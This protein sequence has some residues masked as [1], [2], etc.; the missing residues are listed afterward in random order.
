MNNFTERQQN[1]I[2]FITEH[3]HCT[4]SQLERELGCSRRTIINEIKAI[5]Q[6]KPLIL[7]TNKGYSINQEEASQSMTSQFK[8]VNEEHLLLRRL[9][10]FNKTYTFHELA[11]KQF[12]SESTL[13][14]LLKA[15]TPLL[16]S[17]DLA[18]KREKGYVKVIG[19]EFS[20]RK[21]I[22]Y[23]INEEIDPTFTSLENIT[24][25]FNINVSRI[26]NI[27]DNAIYNHHYYLDNTYSF[28]LYLNIIIALYRMKSD[29]YIDQIPYNTIDKSSVEYQISKE[30]CYQYANH[31]SIS[32][33]EEDIFYIALLLIGQIKPLNVNTDIRL[34][35]PEIISRDLINKMDKVLFDTFNYYMMNINYK[36]FLYNFSLHI[37]AMIKRIKNNQTIQNDFL[38]NIK[39][40]CPF[41]YEVAV[42]IAQK[43]QTEY[44]IIIP[45]E[46]IGFISVHIGFLINKSVD[47]YNKIKILLLCTDYHH[48]IENV[49]QKILANHSEYVEITSY[50]ITSIDNKNIDLNA[51]IIIS[52]KHLNI[53]GKKII[54][55][56]PFYT[57]M[58]HITV[59]S[60]I[61]EALLEK[62]KTYKNRLLSSFFH[63]NLF[64]KSDDFKTKEEVI[65]FLGDK[66]IEF[67]LAEK[68]YTE[69]VLEREKISS[70]CFF[71][72]F[73]IPHSLNQTTKRSMFCV[74]LSDKGINWDG[75]VIHIVLMLAIQLNDRKEFVN[76]YNG[77]I[78]VLWDKEKCE[79]LMK[80]NNLSE[81]LSILK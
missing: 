49:E 38:H 75:K 80:A 66:I 8:Q 28:N 69:S 18:I 72:T 19:N 67:G 14:R 62:E 20:K 27:I 21:L 31:W 61:H 40:N 64:F 58:D 45:D 47:N 15:I 48:L 44:D 25:L 11:E 39:K 2:S 10:L 57:M 55:I 16:S 1:I 13:E 52:T 50:D 43:I 26:K 77:I 73:A 41:I 46:E 29:I 71:D 79:K 33:K 17:F 37:D 59:D 4:C 30:I 5:N 12:I 35:N 36:D 70:T 7:S 3:I 78:K 51:D 53:I 56:T 74:L 34:L 42:H 54:V 22:H 6:I 9:V 81:F 76:I 60:A 68:G 24:Q 23:L 65:Q 63:E 32:P